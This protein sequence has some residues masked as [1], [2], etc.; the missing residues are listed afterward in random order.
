MHGEPARPWTVGELARE[1]ALSRSS[2]YD[3]FRREVGV[4]PM[5]YLLKWRMALAKD[6]LRGADSPAV[7]DV[8]QRV[9]YSSQSTFSVAFSREVGA[10]PR[11]YA[12]RTVHGPADGADVQPMG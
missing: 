8:A 9:G 3:R 11:T 6:L 1:A 5:D 4:V 10:T 7:G 2:F 12:R